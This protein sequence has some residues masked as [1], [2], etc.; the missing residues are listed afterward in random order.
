MTRG[1][2]QMFCATTR[3]E[4]APRCIFVGTRE[5]NFEQVAHTAASSKS[6]DS[7]PELINGDSRIKHQ[8][9]PPAAEVSRS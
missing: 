7:D 6:C 4:P 3:V 2:P 9:C 5:T 1:D 8:P